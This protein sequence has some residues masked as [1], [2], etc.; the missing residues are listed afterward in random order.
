MGNL[1]DAVVRSLLSFFLLPFPNDLPDKGRQTF[2]FP[3][4][5]SDFCPMPLH[6][7][8]AL[9]PDCR[10]VL[11]RIEEDEPTLRAHLVLT[12]PEQAD[13]DG[14]THPNQRVEWLACRVAVQTLAQAHHYLYRGLVKDEYGKPHLLQPESAGSPAHISISHTGGWAAAV[15]HQ[16][17]PVGIDIEPIRA[18]FTR[19]VPRVLS[20]AEIEHAAG[21][22]DRLAVYW[23]AKECLY[24]LYGKRQLTFREHLHIE[25]FAD[26]AE[27]LTGHVR[28]P[29][30]EETLQIHCWAIG[31]GLLAVACP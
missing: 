16:N 31:P 20:E 22:A 6:T 12:A 3:I 15:W 26:G 27:R 28:L 5:T 29:D 10:V 7:T 2:L 24:K 19:V 17:R 1:R 4:Q 30:H 25:P 23:C 11:W 14:I 21:R 13:L 18:Q 9:N 8:F